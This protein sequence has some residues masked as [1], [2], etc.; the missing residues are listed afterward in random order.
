MA[1]TEV[2]MAGSAA[3]RPLRVDARR[4][5][6]RIIAAAGAAFTE[7]GADA[8]LEDIARRAGVGS[9]TLHRRFPSR[10]A[11]LEAVF[12]DRVEALCARVE[13]LEHEAEPGPALITWLRALAAYASG[14]R[15]LAA[16]LVPVAANDAA[17]AGSSCQAMTRSACDRLL[18]RAHQAGA[19]R[20]G[21][22]ST[23]LLTL[24][25]AI[26]LASEQTPGQDQAVRLL[27]LALHGIIPT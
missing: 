23:D 4:N 10:R 1:R 24:V 27:D 15:G 26:S 13:V 21:I 5:H 12:H 20:P 8:S 18:Q 9:A 3:P 2:G 19:V 7:H 6:D 14:T 17:S 25:T 16:A 11:L 22:S